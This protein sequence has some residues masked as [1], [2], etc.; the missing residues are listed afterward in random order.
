VTASHHQRTCIVVSG[1]VYCEESQV[2]AHDAGVM[3]LAFAFLVGYVV[4]VLDHTD[5]WVTAAAFL[6]PATLIGLGLML[7]G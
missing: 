7:F 3:V 4:W 2:T 5:G 1:K 6:V